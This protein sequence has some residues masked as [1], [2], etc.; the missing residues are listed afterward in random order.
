MRAAPA[1][2]PAPAL[3]GAGGPG[4]CG[5]EEDAKEGI[6]HLRPAMLIE[7]WQMFKDFSLRV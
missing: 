5:S 1:G 7:L 2:T 6:F 3:G 4:R